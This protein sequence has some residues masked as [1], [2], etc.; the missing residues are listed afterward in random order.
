MTSLVNNFQILTFVALR[1]VPQR[2]S[3]DGEVKQTMLK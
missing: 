1:K 2:F 3:V